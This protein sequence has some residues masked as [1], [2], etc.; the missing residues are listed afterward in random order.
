MGDDIAAVD[1]ER[2]EAVLA[3]SLRAATTRGI[4]M[5]TAL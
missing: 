4:L 5:T 3:L 1:E 2:A